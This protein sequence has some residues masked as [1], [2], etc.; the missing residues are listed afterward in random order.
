MQ[1][2]IL[3]LCL[4]EPL[5]GYQIIKKGKETGLVNWSSGSFYPLIAPLIKEGLLKKKTT[6]E[7]RKE[8]LYSTTSKGRKYL[9]HISSYFNNKLIKS[10]FTA[11][12][13]NKF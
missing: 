10:Y 6:K 11:L 8:V 2:F 7:N 12:L 1:G 13:K 4:D 3:Y 9:Q 5:N